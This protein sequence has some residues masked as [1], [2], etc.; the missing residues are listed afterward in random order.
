[1]EREEAEQEQRLAEEDKRLQ[2]QADKEQAL[3]E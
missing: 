1:M 3:M 2:D